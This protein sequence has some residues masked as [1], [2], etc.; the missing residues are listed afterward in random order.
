MESFR[1]AW[2]RFK[3]GEPGSRFRRQFEA[4]QKARKSQWARPAIVA[5]GVLVILL[6]LVALP[7]PGPGTLVIAAGA[8]LIA[9]EFLWMARLLDSAEVLIRRVGERLRHR[10]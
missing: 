5:L 8:G 9:R 2:R 4:N 10:A 1:K 6:G 3:A 7:A